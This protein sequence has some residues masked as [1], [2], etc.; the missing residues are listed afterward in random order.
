[1]SNRT[2]RLRDSSLANYVLYQAGWFACVI[3]AARQRPWLGAAIALVLLLAQVALSTQR[4]REVRLIASAVLVGFVVE[5]IHLA[6]GTYV[7][8]SG[9]IAAGWPPAWI[10]LMW[11][12]FAATFAFSLRPII[13]RPA[14]AAAFGA[15]GGPL[16]FVAGHGL[17]AVTLVPPMWLAL[18]QI[19]LAWG[20]AMTLLAAI[21]RRAFST[22]DTSANPGIGTPRPPTNN[23]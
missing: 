1:M 7:F 17:G 19:A 6:A 8:R 4:G 2:G 15:I 22:D 18:L 3:G 16:A 23:Q 13:T 14:A 11:A 21:A 12:Q 20:V 5:S 9:T 10:I